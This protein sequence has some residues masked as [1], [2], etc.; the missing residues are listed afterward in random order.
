VGHA[1]FAGELS[2]CWGIFI[3]FGL[4]GYVYSAILT[5]MIFFVP[6]SKTVFHRVRAFS[7]LILVLL[8]GVLGSS[9][10]YLISKASID[11]RHWDIYAILQLEEKP[12]VE[13][14]C[15]QFSEEYQQLME[16]HGIKL[17]PIPQGHADSRMMPEDQP[18]QT[19]WTLA[20][21][22][23]NPQI[24]WGDLENW[25]PPQRSMTW[26][27]TMAGFFIYA[28]IILFGVPGLAAAVLHIRRTK[29]GTP[30]T[31]L[32]LANTALFLY[33]VLFTVAAF[34]CFCI[35]TAVI[36]MGGKFTD[37]VFLFLFLTIFGA[38]VIAVEYFVWRL[39][40]R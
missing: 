28:V 21:R 39:L 35:I 20:Y 25:N 29:R 1:N 11:L 17:P 40:R 22:I 10:G 26:S 27:E 33:P 38:I 30:H 7:A 18:L 9:G 36:V 16:Q 8:P 32:Y 13:A 24:S 37:E 14:M 31:G 12:K 34:V 6:Q 2:D 15:Q 3:L 23:R 4:A 19:Y 5:F